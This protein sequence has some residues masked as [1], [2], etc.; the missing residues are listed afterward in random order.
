MMER[1][2]EHLNEH[3][4]QGERRPVLLRNKIRPELLRRIRGHMALKLLGHTNV[5][6]ALRE[7]EELLTL[8]AS[9]LRPDMVKWVE[10]AI[11]VRPDVHAVFGD[12]DVVP[13]AVVVPT[14]P[15][16]VVSVRPNLV[17]KDV[18]RLTDEDRA[19]VFDKNGIDA[20]AA[21][22]N[23]ESEE[24]EEDGENGGDGEGDG[25]VEDGQEQEGGR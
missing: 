20:L 3:G 12:W 14:I 10:G 11:M 24:D 5:P 23:E 15:A 2:G 25:D 16:V 4:A 9:Y 18:D 19:F 7:A 8:V 13:P 21:A 1:T 6:G 22:E 17:D